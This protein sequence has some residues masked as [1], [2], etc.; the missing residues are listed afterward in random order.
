MFVPRMVPAT[1]NR[2][3]LWI[4]SGL[5]FW[6]SILACAVRATAAEP[7]DVSRPLSL[8]SILGLAEERNLGLLQAREQVEIARGAK[9]GSYATF[10]PTLRGSIGYDRSHSTGSSEI[11]TQFGRFVKEETQDSDGLGLNLNGGMNLLAIGDWYRFHQSTIAV[12]AASYGFEAA[13]AELRFSSATQYYALTRAADLLEVADQALRLTSEQLDRAQALFELGSVARTDVLQAQVNRAAAERDRIAAANTVEQE[14]ARLAL[15]IGLPV[16]TE[17]AVM[18]PAGTPDTLLTTPESELVRSAEQNRPDYQ[19]SL[20]QTRAGRLSE[21]AAR[22]GRL[23]TVGLEYSYGKSWSSF[24]SSQTPPPDSLGIPLADAIRSSGEPENQRLSVSV[25]L[26][27]PLFDGWVT[28]GNIERAAAERR[29]SERAL[30]EKRLQLGLDVRQSVLTIRTTAEGIR[31]ARQGVAF[32]E[33]SVR[34]QK[35]LYESGGGTLLQ[36]NDSQVQLTRARVSLVEAEVNLRLA[37]A[38]LEKAVGSSVR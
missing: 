15:L 28:K 36:W 16:D 5:V 22:A 14:R 19:Q 13:R 3:S 21:R 12:S 10:L 25:G 18:D 31:S 23:P 9:T 2:H 8:D 32:A 6:I 26:S 29:Q 4:R 38:G 34:L 33:E 20:R 7:V 24:E 30:E 17:L 35:A 1:A 11:P 27:M 37:W